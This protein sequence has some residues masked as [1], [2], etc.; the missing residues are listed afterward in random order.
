MKKLLLVFLI[1]ILGCR[2]SPSKSFKSLREPF[3]TWYFKYH[4]IESTRYVI[5][6][7]NGKFRPIT[8][9]QI[10]EYSSDISRFIIELSH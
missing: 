10:E 1:L 6:K 5:K 8:L 7:Y 4:P 2:H 3:L 9:A